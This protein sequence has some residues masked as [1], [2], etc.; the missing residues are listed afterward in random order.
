MEHE[1]NDLENIDEAAKAFSRL[2]REVTTM[3]LAIEHLID[4]PTRIEIPDYTRTLG[5]MAT[6]IA[7]AASGLRELRSAPALALTP[8]E[9][10][11]QIAAAGAEARKVEQAALT[12]AT[13]TFVQMGREMAGF[14][15][16]AR[17]EQQQFKW[18]LWSGCGG[19]IAGMILTAIIPGLIARAVPES[20]HWPEHM[21]AGTLDRSIADAGERMLAVADPDEWQSLNIAARASP[22]NK[23]ILIRCAKTA[24]VQRKSVRCTIDIPPQN[25]LPRRP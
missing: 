25:E 1:V 22:A 12:D 21:A 13:R 2:R 6:D 3:R 19:M 24:T 5:K 10:T 16:S 14:V 9:L 7:S 17:T 11:Q 18:L 23:A 15:T 8:Q 4:E 20:W